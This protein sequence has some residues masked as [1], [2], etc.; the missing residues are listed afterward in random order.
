[1][2]KTKTEIIKKAKWELNQDI[3]D[4]LDISSKESWNDFDMRTVEI[5]KDISPINKKNNSNRKIRI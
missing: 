5:I 1:M 4:Q 2:V 3:K